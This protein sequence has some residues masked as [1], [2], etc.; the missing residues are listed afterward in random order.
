MSKLSNCAKF[1]FIIYL[2]YRQKHLLQKMEQF[3]MDA[4]KDNSG[5]L[6][7]HE[8]AGALRNAGYKGSDEEI[9]V[10]RG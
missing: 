10:K 1:D 4:D 8:L 6:S 9:L 2:I 5:Q 7:L 3:F